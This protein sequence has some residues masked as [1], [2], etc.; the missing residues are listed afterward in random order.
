MEYNK[1][2]KLGSGISADVFL[3]TFAGKEVAVK[4]ILKRMDP[5]VDKAIQSREEKAMTKLEHPNVLKLI[6]VQE[7]SD[8]KY[9]TQKSC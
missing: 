7:D 9:V 8:F 5:D 1:D 3:G 6:E 4:K 2:K